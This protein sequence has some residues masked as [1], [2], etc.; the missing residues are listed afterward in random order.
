MTLSE[1]KSVFGVP[2]GDYT[3]RPITYLCLPSPGY[4]PW[5]YKNEAKI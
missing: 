4:R 1:V 5:F 3:T 2:P